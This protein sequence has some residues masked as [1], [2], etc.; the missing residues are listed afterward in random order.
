M[1]DDRP[2]RPDPLHW[3]WYALGGGLP[4]RYRDWVLHDVTAP[5]WWARQ[6]V[7]SL[8]QAVPVGIVVA[9]LIPGSFGIRLLAVAGGAAVA[10][11]YVLTF[12]DEAVERRAVKA[13]FPPGYARSVRERSALDD[14]E[15]RRYAQRYRGGDLR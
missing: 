1:A 2:A 12:V 6:L 11:F 3:L 4:P 7:R 9:L 15:A 13:G 14:D 8:I 5:T 10:L